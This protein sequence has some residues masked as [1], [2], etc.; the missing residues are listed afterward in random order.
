[1][2]WIYLVVS[3]AAGA[4]T[5]LALAWRF[6]RWQAQQEDHLKEQDDAIARLHEELLEE[7]R[8]GRND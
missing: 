5:L 4:V 3:T 7:I 1:M 6:G 8:K 2:N